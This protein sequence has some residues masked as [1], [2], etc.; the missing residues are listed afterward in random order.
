MLNK[1]YAL[2]ELL[3]FLLAVA[4][5]GGLFFVWFLWMLTTVRP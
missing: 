3:G 2:A 1:L 5:L 4:L